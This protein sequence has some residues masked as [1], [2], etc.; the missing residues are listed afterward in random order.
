MFFYRLGKNGST[1][2]LSALCESQLQGCHTNVKLDGLSCSFLSESTRE[3][4]HNYNFFTM[5]IFKRILEKS[6]ANNLGILY[7]PFV[8]TEPQVCVSPENHEIKFSPPLAISFTRLN[9][10]WR[11]YCLKTSGNRVLHT[12]FLTQ[13]RLR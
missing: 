8:D 13:W 1:V 6:C 10:V 3:N 2:G 12:I 7:F 11:R 9:R 5:E 4:E